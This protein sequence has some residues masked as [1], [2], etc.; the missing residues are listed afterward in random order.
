MLLSEIKTRVS[1]CPLATANVYSF[2][3]CYFVDVCFPSLLDSVD[4]IYTVTLTLQRG[5]TR[6]FKSL[7]AVY[8]VIGSLGLLDFHVNLKQH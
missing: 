7:D 6:L 1:L 8:N 5:D 4:D 3:G 2:E